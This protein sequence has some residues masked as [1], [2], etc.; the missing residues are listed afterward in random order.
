MVYVIVLLFLFLVLFLYMN[1]R[2]YLKNAYIAR[3]INSG[4]ERN[5][6]RLVIGDWCNPNQIVGD[7]RCI[8]Y[9]SPSSQ[10]EMVTTLL[11]KRLFSLLDESD[12]VLVIIR[13]SNNRKKQGVS[14]FEIP[15]LHEN[16][17]SDLNIKWMWTLCKLPFLFDIKGSCRVLSGVKMESSFVKA[18]CPISELVDFCKSRNIKLEY[19]TIL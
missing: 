18:E 3:R 9:L 15:Y 14:V 8:N 16:T 17:L 1:A 6:Q 19:Y 10:S 12:G 7:Y 11:T 4:V 2:V 13:N 5:V